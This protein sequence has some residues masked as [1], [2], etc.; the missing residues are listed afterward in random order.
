M[1]ISDEAVLQMERQRQKLMTTL[2]DKG[3]IIEDDNITLSDLVDLVNQ[4]EYKVFE[5]MA[6]LTPQ[7]IINDKIETVE[8]SAFSSLKIGGKLHLEN[9]VSLKKSALQG[10]KFTN[11][12]LPNVVSVDGFS[13]YALSNVKNIILPKLKNIGG[14]QIVGESSTLSRIITPQLYWNGSVGGVYYFYNC[15]PILV[16]ARYLRGLITGNV[17]SLKTIIL[18]DDETL[19]NMGNT[20]SFKALEEVYVPQ[21]LL[22]TYK[23][24]TNWSVFSDRIFALEGSKYEAEDWY[25]DEE[26]YKTEEEAVWQ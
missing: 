26:W 23:T 16:D 18:R 5:K 2:R 10:A 15:S 24:A 8:P 13:L 14:N 22:E 21:A 6:T 19:S 9:C 3:F 20:T 4:T 25:L 7:D 12:K 1:Y 17:Y 11:L